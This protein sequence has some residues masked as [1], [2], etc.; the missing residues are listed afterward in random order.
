MD[1]KLRNQKMANQKLKPNSKIG[2]FGGGQLGQMAASAANALGYRTIIFSDVDNCPASFVSDKTI[3]ADYENETALKEFAGQVD[4]AT[5][6]FENI[7]VKSVNFVAKLKPTFPNSNVLKITQNR[8]KEKTFLNQ[9][10]V[11]TAP[12]KEIKNL[13]D[14]KLAVKEFG[15]CVL[16]TATLGYDGKGQKVLKADDNLEEIWPEFAGKELVLEQF[17]N[18]TSEIST[19]I[20][21]STNGETSC[22]EPLK[23][24]HREGILRTSSYPAQISEKTVKLAEEI[25]TKIIKELD[26][27]GLLAVEFFVLEDGNLLV[28]ELAPRPHNSGHFSMDACKT[29]QFEQ[30]IRAIA[31]LPLGSTEFLCSGFMQNL[32][33]DD[34]LKIDELLKDKNAKL[35]LYG[36]EKIADGRKMGHVN[37][38][39]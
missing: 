31:G 10:G 18:F 23:N 11:K 2:I 15:S 3:I 17:V 1:W 20:A 29:S 37:F 27:I 22:Y 39:Q 9:I 25:S 21:K 8:L 13:E 38:L 7:P 33:G 30:F 5:F 32:I 26:L 36:K 4:I 24:V 35:H 19:I 28:N 34:V 6:E 12:F 14:L 16:K